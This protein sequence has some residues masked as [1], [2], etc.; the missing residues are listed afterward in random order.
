MSSLLLLHTP[1]EC[2]IG[3]GTQVCL[4]PK[5]LG[6]LLFHTRESARVQLKKKKSKVKFFIT[7][8]ELKPLNMTFQVQDGTPQKN[9]QKAQVSADSEKAGGDFH[10]VGE[11]R[12]AHPRHRR[13][14]FVGASLPQRW[15][16]FPCRFGLL[17][18]VLSMLGQAETKAAGKSSSLTGWLAL[19]VAAGT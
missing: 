13:G 10:R 12:G 1:E 2:L 7:E 16:S 14:T 19:P 17:A 6:F 8:E 11:G 9:P 3:I 4:S 18:G 15:L 5:S